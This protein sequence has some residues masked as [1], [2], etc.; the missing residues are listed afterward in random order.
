MEMSRDP[1]V[2]AEYESF[3]LDSYARALDT[4]L[5]KYR[6]LDY[7]ET[8]GTPQ[9][10]WRHDIDYC[11]HRALNIA[12]IEADKG[13][14]CVYHVLLS[15]PYYNVLD[16]EVIATLRE[17]VA[18]GHTV[19]LHFDMDVFGPNFAFDQALFEERVIF[20]KN[21]LET[22][23]GTGILSMSFHNFAMHR[24]ELIEADAFCGM[25]NACSS[26]I[27]DTFR[28]VS[29][30]NGIWRY[31]RL[32]DVLEAPSVPHLHILTHPIWWTLEP[33]APIERLR[34][35]VASTSQPSLDRYVE[36]MKRDGRYTAVAERLGI[37]VTE[38]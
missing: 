33:M 14:R 17:I 22:T 29:D 13:A 26:Q 19:G 16:P 20:E 35:F 8:S 25:A 37:D 38:D 21:L 9:V 5:S 32:E 11:P 12:R 2:R 18:L 36:V 31:D 27:R 7:G 1:D 30:S 15:S 24:A 23:L 3:T 4:A 10:I 28:Y 6:F 34:N